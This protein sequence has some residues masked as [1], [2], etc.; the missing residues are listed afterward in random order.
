MKQTIQTYINIS[1]DINLIKQ[2]T[3][4]EIKLK[5]KQAQSRI[6]NPKDERDTYIHY[7]K[8]EVNWIG[9]AAKSTLLCGDKA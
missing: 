6:V 4:V 8:S 7:M 1:E 5:A 3:Q 9:R 2:K